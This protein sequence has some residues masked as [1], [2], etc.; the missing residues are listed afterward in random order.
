MIS[1]MKTP[2]GRVKGLGSA[3]GGTWNWWY[4]RISSVALIPL[5]LWLIIC[6][7]PLLRQS[8]ENII[9]YLRHPFPAFL[10]SLWIGISIYHGYLG[11]QVIMEDYIHHH[12]FKTGLLLALKGFALCLGVWSLWC[13]LMIQFKTF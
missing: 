8:H 6:F 3:R 12:A 4:Q 1:S 11:L 5:G 9:S 13:L 2:L 7:F 10:M